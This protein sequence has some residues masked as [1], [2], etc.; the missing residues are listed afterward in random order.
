M[1]ATA[2]SSRC[3]RDVVL[4]LDHHMFEDILEH[5]Q[6][7]QGRRAR[8]RADRRRLG[9]A[10]RR[11]K[12]AVERETRRAVPAGPARAALGRDRRGVR[13]LDERSAPS[14]IAACTT[15]PKTGARRSTCRPWC[16][17]TWAR[18]RRPASPSRATPRPA[19]S[20]LYGEFLINAQGEDV[21]AGIRTP[22]T[23]PRP[24]ASEAGA[25]KPSM[26]E[27]MPEAFAELTRICDALEKH[28]RD[29]QDIEFTV[30]QGKLWML[31][32]RTGKRTAKAALQIAVD[33]VE[34]RP[35]HAR[36]K[37]CCASIR[38]RST[39]CCIRPSIPTRQ[40]DVHRHRPAGLARRGLRRDRVRR[41]RGRAAARPTGRKVILVRVETSPED[42]HGMHAAEGILTAR[43]GMTCTPRWSRA[44]WASPASPAP[45][46]SRVD[47]DARHA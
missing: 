6:G 34:R 3:I 35:D 46:R 12:D 30:E 44:A 18:P 36:T 38:R 14:P 37:R 24:R 20:E 17:A 42:I 10:R 13:L 19:R 32:T 41:R 2:A 39:S 45:A 15:F 8:H 23:S 40:R 43:G 33:M 4:G 21:V 29:M 7:Q 1:T 31:Q 28:Y 16:S 22:Q 26:E 27:A 5:L 9:R 47:Y 25:D 11:Y